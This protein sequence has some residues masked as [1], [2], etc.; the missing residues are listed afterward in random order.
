[1]RLALAILAATVAGCGPGGDDP[2]RRPRTSWKEDPLRLGT[3]PAP[4]DERLRRAEDFI[5]QERLAEAATEYRKLLDRDRTDVAALAGLGRVSGLMGDAAGSLGFVAR[6]AEL[7][8]GDASIANQLGVALVMN[9]RRQ[10]AAKTFDRA[11]ELNPQDPFAHVNAAL[12]LADLGEWER[13]ERSAKRASELAPKDPTPWLVL[14]RFEVRRGK[15]GEAVPYYREAVRRAPDDGLANY[16][17]GKTLVAAGQR[18]EAAEPLRAALKS[19]PP[20]EIRAEVEAL[21]GGR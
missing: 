2:G 15:P 10:E 6:A 8:P 9:G 4:A 7:R 20:P 3:A 19:A 21:L 18:G 11:V 1:M 12:N 14:G 17:L 16:H 13:A 5:R